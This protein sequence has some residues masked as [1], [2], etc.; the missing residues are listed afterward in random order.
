MEDSMIIALYF[1]R[2]EQAIT[3]T[4]KKYGG[5]CRTVARNILNSHEDSEEVVNDTYLKTWNSIPPEKPSLLRAFLAAITRSLS[6]TRYRT[7]HR[8]KRETNE[9]AIVMDELGELA[10]PHTAEEL[11][12]EKELGDIINRFLATLSKRDRDIFVAR[13]Y[14]VYPVDRIATSLRLTPN[15]VSNILSRAKNKL[16]KYLIKEGY[17]L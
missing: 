12:L 15:Y 3:E 10:S 4:D 13:Y 5:Y 6:L 16:H 17:L 7:A 1:A 14:F 2:D 9:T 8:Q 11:I